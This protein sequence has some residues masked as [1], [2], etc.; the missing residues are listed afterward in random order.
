MRI[1]LSICILLGILVSDTR[2]ADAREVSFYVAVDGN[3]AWSGTLATAN[4]EGSD[5]PFAT[6]GRAVE[7]MRELKAR[8]PDA[9]RTVMLRGGTHFVDRTITL[10]PDDSG[11]DV[12]GRK[13]GGQWWAADCRRPDRRRGSLQRNF[14]RCPRRSV[15]FPSTSR[16]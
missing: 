2:G 11:T 9:A 7:A 14:A 5:G 6:L 15:V 1:L 8:D 13:A 10:T 4:A 16:R 3:D 12:C